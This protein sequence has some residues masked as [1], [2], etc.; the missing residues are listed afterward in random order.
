MSNITQPKTESLKPYVSLHYEHFPVTPFFEQHAE[1]WPMWSG[2][3]NISYL[4][5]NP[6][7]RD[8]FLI[9]P[10][11]EILGSYLLTLDKENLNL[12]AV[13]D[14][15]TH[16]EHATAAPVLKQLFKVSYLMHQK[17][18]SSSVTHHVTDQETQDMAGLPVQF[19]HTPGHTPDLL[20][21]TV[22]S[23]LF[24]GD[25]LFNVS[26]GRAD[27]PGS[28]AG[29]Q[30]QSIHQLAQ[31]PDDF[32]IHPGH[33]YNHQLSTTVHEAKQN[34]SRLQIPSK[35]EFEN[36]MDTYYADKEKPH[37]LKYYVTFNSR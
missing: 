30:Y 37:D 20:T 32:T 31:F 2:E 22:G 12:V 24:T 23:H 6:D 5:I 21:V 4:I 1:I 7:S 25:S 28:D 3:G 27:F 36:Y 35:A 16:A 33:D 11:M 19:F 15:H 29:Q 14:T 18:P 13:I 17:A 34:N 10:D 9:D 8:A 26:C